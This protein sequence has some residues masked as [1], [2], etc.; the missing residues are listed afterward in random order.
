LIVL[1]GI[2]FLALAVCSPAPVEAAGGPVFAAKEDEHV[3]GGDHAKGG[4]HAKAETSDKVNPFAGAVDLTVFT[5][6]I[7]LI[8]FGLLGRFAWPQI[9]E[10]LDKREQ[11]IARD[12]HEAELAKKEAGDLR[13]KLSEEMARVNDQ[14]RQMMDKARQDAQQTAAEELARG[15]SELQ[16]ER[17]RLHRELKIATDDALHKIWEQAADLATVIS[18][19]A[20]R[21]QL[22]AEDHRALLNEALNDFRA[23]AQVRRENLEE[24]RA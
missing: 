9:R 21:K 18:T 17:D 6:V 10:G 3:K 4:E 16:A 14:I 11:A 1:A 7:F 15:K 8:L 13:Q 12:K 23:A 24:A 19:K 20:V 22:S 2:L 5:I